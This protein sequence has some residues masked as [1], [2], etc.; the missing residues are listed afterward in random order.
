MLN[1][2]T[3]S[4]R[5]LPGDLTPKQ[6]LAEAIRVD[7]AGEYG[8][9][10]I[11]EGQYSVLQEDLIAEMLASEE[12]HLAY[13]TSEMQKHKIRPSILHPLW[14]IGGYLLGKASAW[15]GRR[16]AMAQT[17]AVEDEISDHYAQQIGSAED[18]VF[19]DTLIQFKVE[20]EGH[21]DIGMV[22]EAKQAPLYKAQ[23]RLIRMLCKIS[24]AI[25]KKF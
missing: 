20:E 18:E 11:Y 3:M 23:Y 2:T 4:L 15:V 12:E 8:A 25:A 14:H 9:K 7:H 16:S 19:R 13:F 17:V 24:I 5:R 1:V 22:N 21:K 10:R 6:K